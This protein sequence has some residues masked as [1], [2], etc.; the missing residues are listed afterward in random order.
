MEDSRCKYSRCKY[1]RWNNVADKGRGRRGRRWQMEDIADE[2]K[3]AD[4]RI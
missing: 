2:G 3:M 1:C 4:R